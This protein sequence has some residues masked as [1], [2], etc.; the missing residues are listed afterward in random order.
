MP[1]LVAK[2]SVAQK[3]HIKYSTNKNKSMN[4]RCDLDPKHSNTIL[5][6]DTLA[7]DNVPQSYAWMQKDQQLKIQYI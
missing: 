3:I 6:P 4:H 1:S 7:Y 5:S 2:I